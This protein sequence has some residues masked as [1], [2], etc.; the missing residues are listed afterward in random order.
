MTGPPSGAPS[1]GLKE[2][3][4]GVLPPLSIPL[5]ER[6]TSVLRGIESVPPEGGD[7]VLIVVHLEEPVSGGEHA[8]P[9]HPEDVHAISSMNRKPGN[10]ALIGLAKEGVRRPLV[11]DARPGRVSSRPHVTETRPRDTEVPSPHIIEDALNDVVGQP[12]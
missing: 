10:N 1:G 7:T 3:G 6:R 8:A 4:G 9:I 5:I 2:S 12:D 11:R